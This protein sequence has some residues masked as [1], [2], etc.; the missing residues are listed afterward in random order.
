[1]AA[2]GVDHDR[3]SDRYYPIDVLWQS[4]AR[5]NRGSAARRKIRALTCAISAS[6]IR[7]R[8]PESMRHR[9]A[10]TRT[11]GPGA[12]R[13]VIPHSSPHRAIASSRLVAE[14]R[15]EPIREYGHTP[16]TP[17]SARHA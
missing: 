6:A 14:S 9:K 16:F 8:I 15:L 17:Q 12:A 2:D 1:M 13:V 4:F 11:A 5:P 3:E 7:R 10:G